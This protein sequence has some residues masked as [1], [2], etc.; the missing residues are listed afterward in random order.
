MNETFNEGKLDIDEIIAS[1]QAVQFCGKTLFVH[2]LVNRLN[3]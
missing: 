1:V 2:V 3:L